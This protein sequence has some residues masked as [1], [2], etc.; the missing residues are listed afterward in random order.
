M[1]GI[2]VFKSTKHGCS[3]FIRE[4]LSVLELP[5][6]FSNAV[7]KNG[8]VWVPILR[9][10]SGGFTEQVYDRQEISETSI[11]IVINR[12]QQFLMWVFTDGENISPNLIDSHHNLPDNIINY[13]INDVIIKEQRAGNHSVNQHLM[14]L[15]YYYD[16]LAMTGF[17]SANS[18]VVKPMFKDLARAN[19]NPRQ[20]VKYLT[21]ALRSTLYR[22]TNSIRDELLLRTGGEL[23]LRRKENLGLLV[24]DFRVGN[25]LHS[26]FKSLFSEMDTNLDKMQFEYYLQGTFTKSTRN[27]GGGHPRMLYIHRSLLSRFRQYFDEER[28]SSVENTLFLTNGKSHRGTKI[29][30]ALASDV[31]LE[32][33]RRVIALQKKGQINGSMQA[34]EEDHTHHVLRH[35]FG[36]DKFYELCK[37]KNIPFDDVSPTSQVYLSVARLMGHNAADNKAPETT[38]TYIRSCHIKEA[39]END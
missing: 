13:Y 39:F 35:T 30:T 22:N 17:T 7:A 29:S 8:V 14:A 19:T 5:T 1:S 9:R 3:I 2:N 15:R 25:K 10:N 38:K 11:D 16:Y 6:Y 24:N 21:P 33:K 18:I 36:T 27:G 26:G 37:E 28:P 12:L 4:D 34:L 20:A 32:T 31:F 23:G